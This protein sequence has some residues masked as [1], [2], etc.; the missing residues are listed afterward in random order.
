MT[1]FWYITKCL[2]CHCILLKVY[3]VMLSA[4][5]TVYCRIDFTTKQ[6]QINTVW[7]TLQNYV[8][9]EHMTLRFPQQK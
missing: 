1:N 5:M 3:L 8:M 9:Q 2:F 7:K 6:Y 4:S